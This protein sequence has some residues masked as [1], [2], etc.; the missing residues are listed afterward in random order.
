MTINLLSDS[1]VIDT[2]DTDDNRMYSFQV[3]TAGTYV[4]EEEVP[5][6][7]YPTTPT[8]VTV[9]VE[10]GEAYQVDFENSLVPPEKVVIYGFKF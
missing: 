9:Y 3:D 8:K 7:S 4:V 1:S 6:G 5:S 10:E 2:V